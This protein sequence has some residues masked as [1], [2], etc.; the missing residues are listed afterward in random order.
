MYVCEKLHVTGRAMRPEAA[1]TVPLLSDE[2]ITQAAQHDHSVR[3][4]VCDK[5]FRQQLRSSE[6]IYIFSFSMIHMVRVVEGDRPASACWYEHLPACMHLRRGVPA[7][8]V[9][10]NLPTFRD[11]R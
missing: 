6:F 7:L 4:R 10:R 3:Q 5:P 1:L 9:P 8:A 11:Y 2:K